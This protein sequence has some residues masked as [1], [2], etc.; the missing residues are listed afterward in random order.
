MARERGA[1]YTATLASTAEAT[2]TTV[3]SSSHGQRGVTFF[4]NSASVG[5][6]AKVYW[7]DPDGTDRLIDSQTVTAATPLGMDYDFRIPE[8]KFTFTPS[9]G[10]STAVVVEGITY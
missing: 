4:I 8:A 7:V 9:S 6:T 2:A 1:V 10:S 5:G 3:Y